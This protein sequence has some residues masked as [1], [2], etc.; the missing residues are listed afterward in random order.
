MNIRQFS[1]LLVTT[2]VLLWSLG[3]YAANNYVGPDRD[4]NG[5]I[6]PT[7]KGEKCVEPTDVIRATHMNLLKHKRDLTMHQG[8]RTKTHSL[9]E[10]INCHATPGE[11]GKIARV[12][13]DNSKHFCASCHREASVTLDCFECHTDRP[14][15]AFSSLQQIPQSH[16]MSSQP[17]PAADSEGPVVLNRK[18]Q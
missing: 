17:A 2:A 11:D 14:E 9:K 6:V 7:P 18:G 10:C 16:L 3:G 5:N 8:I 1:R 12:F 13:D 4:A 15:D